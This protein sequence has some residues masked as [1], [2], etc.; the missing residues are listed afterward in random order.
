MGMQGTTKFDLAFK[1]IG[2]L[3]RV[4]YEKRFFGQGSGFLTGPLVL[5]AIIDAQV[6]AVC[7]RVQDRQGGKNLARE[8]RVCNFRMVA[9]RLGP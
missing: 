9:A 3:L 6:D 1:L 5:Q 8:D 4:L 7:I 2:Q